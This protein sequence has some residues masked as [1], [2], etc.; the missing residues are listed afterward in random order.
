M[1]MTSVRMSDQLMT[2][3]ESIAVK[4]DRSKGWIIKEAI[5][6]YAAKIKRE[7]IILSETRQ[8]LSEIESG[9]VVDGEEVLDW[10]ESWG[11]QDVKSAPK[12]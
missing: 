7:E 1:P 6:Q 11:T 9:D 10:I 12:I 2:E 4:L 3:L 5:S 8:A